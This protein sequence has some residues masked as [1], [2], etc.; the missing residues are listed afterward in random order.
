VNE[1]SSVTMIFLVIVLLH[2]GGFF[3]NE[4]ATPYEFLSNV[5]ER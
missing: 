1:C 3:A 4:R 5:V 2:W